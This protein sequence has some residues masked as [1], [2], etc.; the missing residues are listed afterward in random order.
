[1]WT[2]KQL[3]EILRNPS[4]NICSPAIGRLREQIMS[5]LIS[6]VSRRYF[7]LIATW[8]SEFLVDK[9]RFFDAF[10]HDTQGAVIARGA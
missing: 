4:L 9:P 7:C 1:M 2:E 10:R 6:H 5:S 3:G 8:E